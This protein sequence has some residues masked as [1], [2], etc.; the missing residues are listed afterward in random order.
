RT[1]FEDKSENTKYKSNLMHH[2]YNP[3]EQPEII[4]YIIKNL[5]LYDLTKCLYINRIWNKEAKRKFFIRQEK[6]QDIFW[7]LESELEEAEEKYAWWIGGGGNTNPEIENPYIRINSLN[8]ELFGIIKRLQ[9]LE[10]Y[11]LSNNI[12]DRI[13]GAHYMY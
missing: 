11:M 8:R 1:F 5:T 10:H 2:T 12:I 13:A 9:E 6:L 3:F 7:K 4:A